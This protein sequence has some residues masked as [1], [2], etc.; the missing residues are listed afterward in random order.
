MRINLFAA[1]LLAFSLPFTANAQKAP[2]A[3]TP[4]VQTAEI[5]VPVEKANDILK[6][7]RSIQG[8]ALAE[9]DRQ[10]KAQQAEQQAQ[11][12]YAQQ[13]KKL[14]DD[15]NAAVEKLRTDLKVPA[16]AQ[17]NQGKVAFEVPQAK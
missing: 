8:A 13:A 3:P 14:M 15:L 10:Q 2:S 7:Q 4:A 17:F 9:T 16:N 11:Q 1:T 6:M 5:P 12:A